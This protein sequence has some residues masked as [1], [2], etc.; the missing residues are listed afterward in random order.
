MLG[1]GELLPLLVA[2]CAPTLATVI[3]IR[4]ANSNAVKAAHAATD[5]ALAAKAVKV[6]L[7]NS[8][9]Q[10]MIKLDEIHVLV[11]GRMTKVVDQAA[12]LES[13]LTQALAKIDRLEQQIYRRAG[14]VES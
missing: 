13:Q 10:T 11:D 1:L 4:I 6:D 12:L 8:A 5:A 9:D 2:L 14:P 3:G 7:A